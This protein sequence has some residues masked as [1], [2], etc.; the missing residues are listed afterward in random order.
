MRSVD[1]KI[2][3]RMHKS[4]KTGVWC[5]KD[6]LDFGERAAIDQAL[7]RMVK[8]R[9][10]RRVARGLYDVPKF[11][12]LLNTELSPSYDKIAKAVA[13][14]LGIKIQPSGAVAANMLGLSEQVPAKIVYLTDGKKRQLRYG[15]STI[16]FQHVLPSRVHGRDDISAMLPSAIRFMGKNGVNDALIAR[17]ISRLP[18]KEC[19][20]LLRGAKYLEAWIYGMIKHAADRSNGNK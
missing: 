15:N 16:L 8:A 9:E 5:N 20:K 19:K 14:K 12:T 4:P 17:L 1:D 7:G 3:F 2:R 10:L 13:R 18:E 11:S 6:F